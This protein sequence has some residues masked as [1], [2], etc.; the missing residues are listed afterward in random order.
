MVVKFADKPD[1]QIKTGFRLYNIPIILILNIDRYIINRC[2]F[3]VTKA[4]FFFQ[5]SQ[6]TKPELSSIML[7][8]ILFFIYLPET[9]LTVTTV[10]TKAI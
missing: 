4:H 3:N 1:W 6:P 5:N 2:Y 10:L 9:D 8:Y 7:Y